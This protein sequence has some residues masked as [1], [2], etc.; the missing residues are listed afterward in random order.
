MLDYHRQNQ[1]SFKSTRICFP[2]WLRFKAMNAINQTKGLEEE[3]HKSVNEVM[4]MGMYE[5]EALVCQNVV[6][7]FP[8]PQDMWPNKREG[9]D[10]Q[11]YHYIQIPLDVEVVD[12]FAMDYHIALFF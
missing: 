7:S 9:I 8:L 12:G 4:K 10:E 5:S 2:M 1:K 6:T 11:K 3:R